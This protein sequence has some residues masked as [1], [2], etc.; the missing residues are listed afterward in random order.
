[1]TSH[2]FSIPASVG[3]EMACEELAERDCCWCVV[4]V[5]IEAEGL[6]GPLVVRRHGR[7][8][9]ELFVARGS[10]RSIMT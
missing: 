6:E 10:D 1:M 4:D 2:R 9:K 8:Y 5:H 3:L 7:R